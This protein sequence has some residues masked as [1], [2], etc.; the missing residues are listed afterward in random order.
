VRIFKERLEQYGFD[1]EEIDSVQTDFERRKSHTTSSQH[2]VYPAMDHNKVENQT[3]AT[4]SVRIAPTNVTLVQEQRLHCTLQNIGES[5]IPCM[6]TACYGH[7][8]VYRWICR[9]PLRLTH[10]THTSH[11]S[12]WLHFPK[13]GTSF[14]VT[15][16][17]C[18]CP[19]STH[20]LS[21]E[22]IAAKSRY[23]SIQ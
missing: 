22:N 13:C 5:H 8:G 16:I 14:G 4:K 23:A 21:L 17:R 3:E 2:T 15:L 7:V 18:A 20:K 10:V 11:A 9:R 6:L 1:K 12:V 19:Q